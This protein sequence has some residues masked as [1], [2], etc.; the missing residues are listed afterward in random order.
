MM[1]TRYSLIGVESVG[2]TVRL[3]QLSERKGERAVQAWA[4]FPK[5]SED[6]GLEAEAGR[7]A[8]VL[9]RR[10]FVGHDLAVGLSDEGVLSAVLDLPPLK[11]GAPVRTIAATEIGRM[12]KQSPADLELALW[13]LPITA[14]QAGAVSCMVVACPHASTAPVFD[15]FA[16][17]DLNVRLMEPRS[18]ALA[19]A[20]VGRTVKPGTLD[21]VLSLGW[22]QS[23]FVAMDTSAIV[24]ERAIE[25]ADLETLHRVVTGTIG[26]ETEFAPLAIRDAM[27]GKR[28]LLA[29]PDACREVQE[30]VRHFGE[31]LSEE[32]MTAISYITRRCGGKQVTRLMVVSEEDGTAEI[33]TVIQER[34]AVDVR[35]VSLVEIGFAGL[36]SVSESARRA[37]V[38]CAGLC[39][40]RKEGGRW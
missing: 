37:L 40:T 21:A 16:E 25:G 3:L 32:L 11:S 27:L 1:Q 4:V 22:K 24:L 13:E 33:A 31:K 9:R 38:G 35:S 7:I 18:T 23:R 30:Q 15:A 5:S 10:G 26:L 14:R 2:R 17:H 12:F 39:L 19:R 29:D 28:E 34:V 20:C 8:G 36:D 6:A